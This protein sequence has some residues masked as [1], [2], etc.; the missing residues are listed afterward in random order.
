MSGL[1]AGRAKRVNPPLTV[2][3]KEK[4]VRKYELFS[5]FICLFDSEPAEEQQFVKYEF[6]SSLY[7][8]EPSTSTSFAEYSFLSCLY[9]SELKYYTFSSLL[10]KQN[11]LI[12]LLAPFFILTFQHH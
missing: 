12:F 11:H 10:I 8:S 5:H 4:R 2:I 7:G 3:F 6:L 1:P 9:G